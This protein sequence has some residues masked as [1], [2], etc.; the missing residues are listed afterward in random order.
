MTPR[1]KAIL[2]INRA[3]EELLDN[4]FQIAK[5]V[6][7]K[8]SKIKSSLLTWFYIADKDGKNVIYA[9]YDHPFDEWHFSKPYYPSQENGS[10]ARLN[11]ND[12]KF[13]VER[14]KEWLDT[15]TDVP[16]L[17]KTHG[18]KFNLKT[19]RLYKDFAE[20][21]ANYLDKT[22]HVRYVYMT[23]AENNNR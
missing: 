12:E 20:L 10:S 4:G 13:S 18:Y 1:E 7:K 17:V 2:T 3:I 5:P 19:L 8:D 21:K 23:P 22:P 16:S 15:I 11:G 14:I 6:H 9:E